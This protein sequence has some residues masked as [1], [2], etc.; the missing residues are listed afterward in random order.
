MPADEDAEPS[1]PE[2]YT[3]EHEAIAIRVRMMAVSHRIKLAFTGGREARQVLARDP[4]RLVQR[5][6]LM[7]PRMSLEEVLAVAKNRS[8]HGQLLRQIAEQRDWV[9]QYSIRQALVMNPKTPLQIALKLMGGLHERDVRVLAKS[10]N[11]SSVVQA[12]A[13]RA[14]LRK[15]G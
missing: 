6:V 13:R 1:H 15:Q 12:Q 14:L 4:V 10:R 2:R 9:R 8:L 7:N 3:P 5:C 11:V